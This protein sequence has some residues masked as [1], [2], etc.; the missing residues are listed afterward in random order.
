MIDRQDQ[1]SRQT[2]SGQIGFAILALGLCTACGMS[3]LSGGSGPDNSMSYMPAGQTTTNQN[4]E[5]RPHVSSSTSANDTLRVQTAAGGSAFALIVRFRDT[6]ELEEIARDFRRDPSGARAKFAKWAA[7]KPALAGLQLER[8]SYSGELVL[9]SSGG[10]DIDQTIAAIKAM[11][12]V[13]YVEKDY[14]VEPGKKG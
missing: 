13:A 8:A 4:E 10:R 12:N 3:W 9:I 2:N 11:D 5:D 7:G 14:S 6:P 1:T